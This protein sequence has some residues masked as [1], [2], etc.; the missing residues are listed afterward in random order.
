MS[1]LPWSTVQQGSD[2]KWVEWNSFIMVAGSRNECLKSCICQHPYTLV[3]DEL[4]I[5]GSQAG[6]SSQ[7]TEVMETWSPSSLPLTSMQL[8]LN[9]PL[10]PE[11]LDTIAPEVSKINIIQQS[12]QWAYHN[13]DSKNPI[14][15]LCMVTA[16]V[17]DKL[18]PHYLLWKPNAWGSM[19]SNE[20]LGWT[21][22][23]THS[24][25]LL[26]SGPKCF[27][28]SL[29]YLL[30]M[31]DKR[32]PIH[33]CMDSKGGISRWDWGE[34]LSTYLMTVAVITHTLTCYVGKDGPSLRTDEKG[35]VCGFSESR[36]CLVERASSSS[37]V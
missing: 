37:A 6:A 29:L 31:L 1:L 19:S 14:H 17:V 25:K 7:V 5:G 23:A 16:W 2:S 22:D 36:V 8:H 32:S 24:R 27:R 21:Q 26:K 10:T 20:P 35:M 33:Q 11:E 13:Y 28:W 15:Q 34:T 4:M 18:A 9:I 30:T 3:D 12:H